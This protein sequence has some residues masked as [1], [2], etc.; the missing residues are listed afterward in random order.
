M[1]KYVLLM[2]AMIMTVMSG[3]AFDKY[4]INR[5]DLPESAQQFLTTYFPK[6]K[7]GMIKTDKHFLKKTDYDVKLVNGT[8]IEFNNSGK[9]TSVDCKGREVPKDIIPRAI[10]NYVI[11]NFPDVKIVKIEKTSSKYEVGLSDDVELIFNLLGQFKSVK[12]DD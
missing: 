1:K 11:K 2:F 7:V 4:S 8:K 9:W 6:A 10:R 3:Y 12:M 5:D